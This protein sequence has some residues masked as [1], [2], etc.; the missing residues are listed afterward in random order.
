MNI[1]KP[2][3]L[4]ITTVLLLLFTNS[5]FSQKIEPKERM[6]ES[7]HTI[8][9]KILGRDYQLYI[10]FPKN[11]STKDS[12]SYPVLYVLDGLIFLSCYQRSKNYI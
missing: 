5:L 9:S 1:L 4:V 7:D 10:S 12:I 11:Y 6:T 8:T 3:Q 2:M